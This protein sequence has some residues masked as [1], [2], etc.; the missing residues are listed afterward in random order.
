MKQEIKNRWTGKV[1]FTAEIEATDSTPLPFRIG[2]AVKWAIKNNADLRAADLRAADLRAADLRDADL[3][4]ANLR[5][6]DLRDAKNLRLPTG[7]TWK[8]YLTKTV[9]AL[10][11]AGGKKLEEVATPE[12]W[13]C[14]S[15]D[16]CPMAAAFGVNREEETPLLLR[17]RVRQFVQLFDA[18]QIKLED[19]L[20]KK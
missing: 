11:V 17:P 12:H 8:E 16:N 4:A 9:P 7:E 1:Q 20:P 10:L 14:H 3:R 13:N 5:D 15:W 19:I 6:A 18:H 2:L